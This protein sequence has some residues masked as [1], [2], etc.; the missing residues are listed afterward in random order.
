MTFSCCWCISLH[1]EQYTL[2][3]NDPLSDRT[4]GRRST[5]LFFVAHEHINKQDVQCTHN[6]TL[7]CLR[8]NTVAMKVQHYLPSVIVAKLH[9]AFNNVNHCA[10]PMKRNNGFPWQCCRAAQY[11]ILLSTISTYLAVDAKGPILLSD[12]NQNSILSTDFQ[13][14]PRY[15]LSQKSVQWKLRGNMRTDMTKH[16][17]AFAT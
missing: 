9:V 16:T 5:N 4:S 1:P 2:S 14:S 11:F 7:R 3:I 12:F 15:Q 8:E 10:L 17:D 6:I 13:E